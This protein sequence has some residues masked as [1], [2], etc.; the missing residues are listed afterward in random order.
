M[1]E[2]LKQIGLIRPLG[3]QEIDVDRVIRFTD[4]VLALSTEAINSLTNAY[5]AHL[6]DRSDEEKQKGYR[7]WESVWAIEPN[8]GVWVAWHKLSDRLT[9][10]PLWPEANN[11]SATLNALNGPFH[12]VFYRDRIDDSTYNFLVRSWVEAF[13]EDPLA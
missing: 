6:N 12:G 9:K 5:L 4:K 3:L 10:P 8:D 13:G 2:K 1:D 7:I 11:I